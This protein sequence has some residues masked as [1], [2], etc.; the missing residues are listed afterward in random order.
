M[1]KKIEKITIIIPCYN[2]GKFLND[3]IKSV[4]YQTYK[5]FDLYLIN[6]GST[7]NSLDIMR[8]HESKDKRIFVVNYK[9][10]TSRGKSVNNLLKRLKTK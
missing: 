6:N 7:D 2:N 1:T 9:K 3:S 10:K 5:N 8:I 4:L